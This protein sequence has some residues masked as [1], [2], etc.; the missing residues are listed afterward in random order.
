MSNQPADYDGSR[1]R[2]KRAERSQMEWH[3]ASLNELISPDHR[4]RQVWAYVEGLD[5][6]PLY[7]EIKAV[8]GHVGRDA[9]DPRILVA[10]W[11]FA[12][13]ESV[14]SARAL[15]RLCD[16]DLAYMWICGGVSVNY[17]L[18]SDFRTGNGGFL[19]ELL[20]DTVATLLHRK[21]VTLETVAQDGMRVRANAGTSSFHSEPT[22]QECRQQAAAHL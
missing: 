1:A 7:K 10:L 19:S 3:A 5:L 13:I 22:L 2:V 12:T 4:V 6:S 8:E 18:L 14:N 21:I 16:R 17:H 20:T 11:L 9:V 15:A